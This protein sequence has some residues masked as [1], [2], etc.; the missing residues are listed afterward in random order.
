MDLVNE[1]TLIDFLLNDEPRNTASLI[2]ASPFI[3][4]PPLDPF[5]PLKRR[6]RKR[7]NVDKTLLVDLEYLICMPV[8][9]RQK[10]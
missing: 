3:F 1:S 9:V 6:V 2:Q 8:D 10:S 5:K 7:Q 4:E